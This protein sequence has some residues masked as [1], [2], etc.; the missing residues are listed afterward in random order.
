MSNLE[1][2]KELFPDHDI[3]VMS[4]DEE[5]ENMYPLVGIVKGHHILH[6]VVRPYVYLVI[7]WENPL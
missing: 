5:D 2:I 7:D 6:D 3:Y 1:K 4:E